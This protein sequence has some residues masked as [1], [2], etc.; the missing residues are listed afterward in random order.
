M[1]LPLSAAAAR[2]AGVLL[3]LILATMLCGCAG[4]AAGP[5]VPP[6]NDWSTLPSPAPPKVYIN[7]IL[8]DQVSARSADLHASLGV[9]LYWN[10][11]GSPKKLENE[12]TRIFNYI[13]GL[14]ANST[15]INFPFYT[16]GEYPS[17][18]YSVSSE[19]PSPATIAMAVADARK[20][21]LRVLVRPV[22]NDDNIKVITKDWRGSIEPEPLS[23]WFASYYRFLQPYLTA[24][25]AGQANSFDIDTELDSLAADHGDWSSLQAKAAT[26]FKG[27]IVYTVN[28]GLWQEDRP[29]EPVPDA[30][31]DAYPQLNL[32]DDATVAELTSAWIAWLRGHRTE[33]V[34]KKTVLQEVGIAAVAGA[35][36]APALTAPSGTRLDLSVQQKWFAAACAAA[37]QTHVAGLYF[38][39]V[40]S[41]D[42]PSDRAA[43]ASYA[44]G[45]FIDRSDG[46][47]RACFASG[48]S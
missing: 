30:A 5:A 44:P 24:A 26:L 7:G 48:W 38:F 31:V 32:R 40:N 4:L 18:V 23:A 8:V 25:Q 45:S 46:V 41:T 3:S 35:Y 47:I 2:F 22:L 19:T 37:K 10:S 34:L 21:G 14:G 20:H 15:A 36:A 12:A 42:N 27:N 39:D 9:Q 28:Y 43:A 1:S 6:G 16:N 13:V 33:S 17:R 29:D 11:S